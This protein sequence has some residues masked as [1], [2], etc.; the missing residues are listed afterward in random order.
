VYII[1]CI[2]NSVKALRYQL[3][4]IIEALEEVSREANDTITKSEP[5]SLSN[6]LSTFEFVLSLVIWYNILIAVNVVSKSL[7]RKNIDIGRHLF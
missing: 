6:E 3:S 5:Q 4:N 2:I 7:Q 1:L